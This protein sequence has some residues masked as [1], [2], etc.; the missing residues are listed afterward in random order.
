ML[1][2]GSASLIKC[3]N[4]I[5]YLQTQNKEFMSTIVW[6]VFTFIC[7][8]TY[9]N[10]VCIFEFKGENMSLHIENF[11]RPQLIFAEISL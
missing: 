5:Q 8:L 2:A 1:R 10:L 4:S 11:S 3:C 7:L 9:L 6:V